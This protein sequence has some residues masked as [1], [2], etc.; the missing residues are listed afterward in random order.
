MPFAR[1]RKA[2]LFLSLSFSLSLPHRSREAR[3]R[4]PGAFATLKEDGP[5][6]PAVDDGLRRPRGT[7]PIVSSI[8]AVPQVSRSSR[9]RPR[10]LYAASIAATIP[11]L[12]KYDPVPRSR[13]EISARLLSI[14]ESRPL[15]PELLPLLPP[16]IASWF[17]QRSRLPLE[18]PFF[19]FR[20]S[21]PSLPSP[22]S[23]SRSSSDDLCPSFPSSS[24]S[25][26]RTSCP[27]L[28]LLFLSL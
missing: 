17:I 6:I 16:R 26:F 3:I 7:P 21:F 18:R 25:L 19:L 2:R 28:L 22:S 13:S 20:S 1:G 23:F 27:S 12:P 9:V 24:R 11:L 14:L 8:G 15:P 10:F 5:K 4:A